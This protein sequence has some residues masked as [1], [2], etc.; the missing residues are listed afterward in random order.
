VPWRHKKGEDG[1]IIC[2]GPGCRNGFIPCPV[3]HASQPPNEQ[4]EG[5]RFFRCLECDWVNPDPHHENDYDTAG[6]ITCPECC[7]G[8]RNDTYEGPCEYC[9]K[10]GVGAKY[11][12]FEGLV[13]RYQQSKSEYIRMSRYACPRCWQKTL[14]QEQREAEQWLAKA[15][16]IKAENAHLKRLNDE[17][18]AAT[19]RYLQAH[20]LGTCDRCRQRREL[21]IN[22][23]NLDLFICVLCAPASEL[24]AAPAPARGPVPGWYP[25]PEYGPDYARYWTGNRWQGEP[26]LR[27]ELH[28]N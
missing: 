22:E 26:T 1:P 23:P 20:K 17:R 21:A 15:E 13:A 12:A 6:M 19:D 27:L 5:E 10:L 24:A 8:E 18:K 7:A 28:G 11:R 4:W 3:D 2:T 14:K 25:D 9:N 16:A